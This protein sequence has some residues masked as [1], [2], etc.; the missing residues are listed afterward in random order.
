MTREVSLP[1]SCVQ[2]CNSSSKMEL[3]ALAGR[4]ACESLLVSFCLIPQVPTSTYLR[5]CTLL[6]AFL[7]SCKA[8]L[9][10]LIFF[11]LRTGKKRWSKRRKTWCLDWRKTKV[12]AW[13]VHQGA[14]KTTGLC[15][16]ACRHVSK[17]T[18]L[19]C[20]LGFEVRKTRDLEMERTYRL[21]F[22]ILLLGSKHQAQLG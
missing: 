6:P 17:G 2:Y 14:W 19:F 7:L 16:P 3:R 15:Y 4:R 9:P 20:F 1:A 12:T 21:T 22:Q 11:W 5:P 8:S 13:L 18:M 10:R